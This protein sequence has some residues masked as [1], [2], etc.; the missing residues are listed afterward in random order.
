MKTTTGGTVPHHEGFAIIHHEARKKMEKYLMA[1]KPV[2]SSIIQARFKG[3]Q[4]NLSIIQC[5]APANDSNDRNKE[6]SY[7]QLQETLEGLL[8]TFFHFRDFLLV[9]GDLNTKVGS[10]NVNFERVMGREGCGV[11]ND[12]G[13]RLVE[14]CASYNMIIGGTLF[15]YRNIHKLT[16]T[17]PNERDQN[18]RDHLMVNSIYGAAPCL[19]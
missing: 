4:T 15:P 3:R 18:Q 9:I 19:T 10:D 2:N 16:C 6:A 5:Y 1:W 7:E 17:S 12:N 8:G 13:E 11:Q 14:W